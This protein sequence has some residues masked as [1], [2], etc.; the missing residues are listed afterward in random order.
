M[1]DRIGDQTGRALD[2][3]LADY[4]VV[5]AQRRPGRSQIDDRLGEAGER[6]QLDRALDLDDLGLAA[7]LL[8]CS[9]PRRVILVATRITPRRRSA[10]AAG[11]T[12]V[13][14]LAAAVARTI[15]QRPKPRSRSS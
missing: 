13:V 7:G 1:G 12:P 8:R 10:S 2:D 14:S 4:Q 11:S 9:G 5:L 6:R 15:V 3:L